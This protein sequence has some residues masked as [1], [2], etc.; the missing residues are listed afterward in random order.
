MEGVYRPYP[1]R[2]RLF[3]RVLELRRGWLGYGR[4]QRR[5]YEDTG[6]WIS[7]SLISYWFRGIHTAR[8]R[9]NV[10]KKE[11]Y[12]FGYVVG[13]VL[14]DGTGTYIRATQTLN[15]TQRIASLLIF[16]LRL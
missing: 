13:S 2:V 6:E 8:G 1:V 15:F 14:S 11:G 10:I 12:W 3:E 7:K 16:V 5:L 9:V 4:I